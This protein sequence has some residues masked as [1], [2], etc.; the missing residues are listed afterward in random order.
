MCR[1][2]YVWICVYVYVDVCGEENVEKKMDCL[3]LAFYV[4]LLHFLQMKNA[5]VP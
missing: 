3:V 5:L 4:S 1:Y 2:V